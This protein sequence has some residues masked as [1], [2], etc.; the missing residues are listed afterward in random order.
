[1]VAVVVLLPF[2]C[3]CGTSGETGRGAGDGDFQEGCSCE[4]ANALVAVEVSLRLCRLRFTVTS[5]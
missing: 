4:V 1:M 3:L 5:F 2:A